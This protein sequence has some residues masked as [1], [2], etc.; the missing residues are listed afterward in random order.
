MSSPTGHREAG[1]HHAIHPASRDVLVAWAMVVAMVVLFVTTASIM[2]RIAW[3]PS[4][5]VA[6]LV[7]GLL[8]SVMLL[9]AATA[10]RFGRRARLRGSEAGIVPAAIGGTIGALLLLLAVVTLVGHALGFE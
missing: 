6:M 4:F 7:F 1:A 8:V 9:L 10:V 2:N 3:D 5:A